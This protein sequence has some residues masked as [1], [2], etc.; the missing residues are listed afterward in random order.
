E[1]HRRQTFLLT[2]GFQRATHATDCTRRILPANDGLVEDPHHTALRGEFG[3]A[4]GILL[5]L[6]GMAVNVDRVI[7][8]NNPIERRIDGLLEAAA[9]RIRGNRA[10]CAR[11]GVVLLC[12]VHG[13]SSRLSSW[14]DNS[15][16]LRDGQTFF[17]SGGT[18]DPRAKQIGK[19]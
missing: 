14:L 2:P 4:Q 7:D 17:R 19:Y 15:L 16:S 6:M 9:S 1:M 5:P 10:N 11:R 18:P 8:S 12:V 13:Q 3:D